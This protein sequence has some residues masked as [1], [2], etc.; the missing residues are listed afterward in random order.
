[1][2]ERYWISLVFSVFAVVFSVCLIIFVSWLFLKGTLT[3]KYFVGA[4]VALIVAIILGLCWMI[5]FIKDYKYVSANECL[6]AD[7]VVVEFTCVEQNLDG[8]GQTSYT[9]PKFYIEENNEY[10]VLYA[11]SVEVGKKYRI[12]YLPNSKLCDVLY[13][14]E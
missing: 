13:T 8:N 4:I 5:P 9:K 6:E 7:A 10:V 2:I 11:T 12:R 1:M 3:K 14:L